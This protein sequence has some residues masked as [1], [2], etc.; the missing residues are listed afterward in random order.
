MQLVSYLS[1]YL[2]QA[3][4]KKNV[5]VIL[6]VPMLYELS[7]PFIDV[8]KCNLSTNELKLS[9]E[10]LAKVYAVVPVLLQMAEKSDTGS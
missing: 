2:L 4:K 5:Y 3:R 10:Y 9:A 8:T 1:S 6:T 7:L